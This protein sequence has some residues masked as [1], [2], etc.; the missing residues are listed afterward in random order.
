MCRLWDSISG[1]QVMLVENDKK[2]RFTAVVWDQPASELLLGD[3]LGFLYFYSLSTEK[4]VKQERVVEE[5]GGEKAL[6]SI[7]ALSL[8]TSAGQQEVIVT[9]L[10]ATN[11][12]LVLREVEYSETVG[13]EGAIIGLAVSDNFPQLPKQGVGAAVR[14]AGDAGEAP[15]PAGAVGVPGSAPVIAPVIYSAA[16]DNTIRAWDP[17]DMATLS[18]MHETEG[19]CHICRSRA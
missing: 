17:Y 11:G 14:A 3:E 15:A 10:N 7:R 5:Q 18:I 4:C 8:H 2:C 16:L 6:S 19:E 1:A 12:W 13:H 9:S